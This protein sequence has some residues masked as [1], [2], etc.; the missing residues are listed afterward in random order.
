[1]V[2]ALHVE[3]E[4]LRARRA[5]GAARDPGAFVRRED[6][7]RG[8][9]LLELGKPLVLGDLGLAVDRANFPPRPARTRRENFDTGLHSPSSR[10]HAY[11]TCPSPRIGSWTARLRPRATAVWTG[12]ASYRKLCASDARIRFR[13]DPCLL[14]I[15]I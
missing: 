13:P 2:E 4:V 1:M 6:P 11:A 15:I 8:A 7:V 3:A 10:R 5:R 14:V 9:D 12:G